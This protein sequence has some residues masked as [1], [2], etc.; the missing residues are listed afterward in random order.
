MNLSDILF[1]TIKKL[2]PDFVNGT[3]P[4]S[5]NAGSVQELESI[6][7]KS[8]VPLEAFLAEATVA[9]SR[10][11]R[12]TD[13]RQIRN[14]LTF[15]ISNRPVSDLVYTENSSVQ[16]SLEPSAIRECVV[17]SNIAIELLH[18]V[19]QLYGIDLFETLGLRNLSSFIGE[20]LKNQ[21]AHVLPDKLIRNPN[22]DGY[23]DLCTLTPEGKVYIDQNRMPDGSINPDKSLW[24]SYS[25]GGVE[26][27]A[28]CGNTPSASVAPKPKIGESRLPSMTHAEWKAHHQ[29]TNRLLGVF[30]DFIDGL[31]T[32]LAVF[33]RNDLDTTI[34]E[35]NKDWGKIQ[36]PKAGAGR[37]TSV[38]IMKQGRTENDGVKK[39]GKGWLVLPEEQNLRRAVCRIFSITL[40]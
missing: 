19:S 7:Q 22:Q 14:A 17:S 40:S 29:E 28:T 6:L 38:S 26:I 11:S 21:I 36:Q 5:L 1:D 2:C 34:G 23:P 24:S 39:M 27:K 35:T 30:W 10:S 20:T 15:Q 16:W 12:S 31:P 4:E 18:D 8:K 32:I 3:S 13:I 33:F 25:Y 37:T 9:A